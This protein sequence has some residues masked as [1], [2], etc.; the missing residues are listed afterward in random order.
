MEKP[1][2]KHADFVKRMELV[3][4]ITDAYA[5]GE[6]DGT[7]G[8]ECNPDYPNEMSEDADYKTIAYSFGW[9][10]GKTLGK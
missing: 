8:D 5:D 4:K 7:N 9:V 6:L 2:D 1:S 10:V 3:H